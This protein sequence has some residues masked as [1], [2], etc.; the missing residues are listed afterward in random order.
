[1]P[2]IL[3]SKTVNSVNL[4]LASEAFE[5]TFLVA[6]FILTYLIARGQFHKTICTSFGAWHTKNGVPK[7]KNKFWSFKYQNE[8]W[9]LKYNFWSLKY[10]NFNTKTILTLFMKSAP[11]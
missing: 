1:M 9:W 8:N 10:Q 3:D 11:A 5:I 6:K 2:P 7:T 4:K